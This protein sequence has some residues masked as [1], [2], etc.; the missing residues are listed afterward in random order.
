MSNSS[1]FRVFIFLFPGVEILDF[2]GPMECFS[3]ANQHTNNAFQLI[4]VAQPILPESSPFHKLN[5]STSSSRQLLAGRSG[6]L[7]PLNYDLTIDEAMEFQF[8][9]NQQSYHSFL[10][11]AD[12]RFTCLTPYLFVIPGGQTCRA[13]LDQSELKM[14]L[15]KFYQQAHNVL[16]VCTG[17]LLLACTGLLYDMKCLLTHHQAIEEVRPWVNEHC[18][19]LFEPSKK[20]YQNERLWMT[21]GVSSGIDGAL[22]L[23][24]SL[25]G[26]EVELKIR[27]TME[28]FYG[29]DEDR[30]KKD[31]LINIMKETVENNQKIAQEKAKEKI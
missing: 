25:F 31:K 19:I 27:Q 2:L 24:S 23:I 9:S 1:L 20:F 18:I 21:S 29:L 30:A 28:Y 26:V 12:D 3:V 11:N 13:L 10:S 17:S 8:G 6:G 5:R 4:T 22:A 7:L 14:K 15:S 16:T